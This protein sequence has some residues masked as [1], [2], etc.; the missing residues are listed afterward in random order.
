MK[1]AAAILKDDETV[2]IIC[3]K[4]DMVTRIPHARLPGRFLS[5]IKC[6]CRHSFIIKVEHRDKF[7]KKVNFPGFYELAETDN[8]ELKAGANV[9]W[10]SVHIDRKIPTCLVTDLS[11]HGI[12]FVIIDHRSLNEGDIVDLTFNLDDSNETKIEQRCK[13]ERVNEKQVGCSLIGNNV[14]LGFYLLG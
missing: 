4:C 9:R 10:E 3:P 8:P 6:R 13:V 7:R 11:R 1:I 5:R 12:G 2:D 14:K